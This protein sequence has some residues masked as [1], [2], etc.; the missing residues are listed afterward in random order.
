LTYFEY[1]KKR[2]DGFYQ[3]IL[4]EAYQKEVEKESALLFL[5]CKKIGM[6]LEAIKVF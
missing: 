5:K 3:K 1:Q 2:K 4:Q 6:G